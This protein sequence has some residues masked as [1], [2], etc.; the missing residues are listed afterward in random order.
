MSREYSCVSF[1]WRSRFTVEGC[2]YQ[3]KIW[4]GWINIVASSISLKHT[5]VNKLCQLFSSRRF[6]KLIM[7]RGSVKWAYW[8][9]YVLL[10]PQII[11]SPSFALKIWRPFL[12]QVLRSYVSRR[13]RD[14][15]MI[16]SPYI[17]QKA[18]GPIHL[19]YETNLS[20]LMQSCW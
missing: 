7:E 4:L 13:E 9:N 15:Q 18:K 3:Q 16:P 8:D 10:S 6:D 5:G 17:H 12:F 1:F 14:Y 2:L 19:R 20:H 11:P